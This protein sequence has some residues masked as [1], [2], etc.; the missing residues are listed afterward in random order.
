MSEELEVYEKSVSVTKHRI[1]SRERNYREYEFVREWHRLRDQEDRYL[2]DLIMAVPA[3]RHDAGSFCTFP[4]ASPVMQPIGS[5]TDRDA[6]VAET[7]IQWLGTNCGQA[8]L[9]SAMDKCGYEIKQKESNVNQ[10][11]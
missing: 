10:P 4:G 7:V 3:N 9:V 5:P 8:F 11:K 1:I 6:Q 2:L